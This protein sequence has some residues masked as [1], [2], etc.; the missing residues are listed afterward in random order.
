MAAEI[1]PRPRLWLLV[2]IMA[3]LQAQAAAA[4]SAG[5]ELPRVELQHCLDRHAGEESIEL[6]VQCPELARALQAGEAAAHLP[7]V[8]DTPRRATLENLGR[9]LRAAS[10]PDADT[11]PLMDYAS[12]AGILAEAHRPV[13]PPPPGLWV[14]FI[15]WLGGW[16]IDS[17]DSR[18]LQP[19]KRFF[20]WVGEH[21][22]LG[23]ILALL[24]LGAL[25]SLVILA[26]GLLARQLGKARGWPVLAER[27]APRHKPAAPAALSPADIRGLPPARQPAA[28]LRWCIDM[29]VRRNALPA[30]RSRTNRELLHC[31]E[32]PPLRRAFARLVETAEPCIYGGRPVDAARLDAL[33]KNA[34]VL[35]GERDGT[36]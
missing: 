28:L 24:L 32:E 4:F 17:G 35:S 15:R 26:V 9:L 1:Q 30:G 31:L 36:G 5:F 3:A 25:V 14:R 27:P 16:L 18:Y 21:V 8:G 6:A 23:R 11:A 13:T 2:P 12:L 33:Y 22:P 10:R 19:L 34:A 29:L 20:E 7:F